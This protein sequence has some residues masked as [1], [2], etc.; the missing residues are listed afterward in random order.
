MR[1]LPVTER[2]KALFGQEGASAVADWIETDPMAG[3]WRA[4]FADAG[5]DRA[6]ASRARGR[7]L[8]SEADIRTS[9]PTALDRLHAAMLLAVPRQW[10]CLPVHRPTA[11]AILID[12]QPSPKHHLRKGQ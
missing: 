6:S 12:L 9:D 7:R 11:V 4:L 2:S 8:N 3:L 5:D 1:L 10:G